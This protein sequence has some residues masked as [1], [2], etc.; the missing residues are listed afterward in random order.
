MS[1]GNTTETDVLGKI[2]NICLTYSIIESNLT[3]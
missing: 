1:F 3:I 2:F